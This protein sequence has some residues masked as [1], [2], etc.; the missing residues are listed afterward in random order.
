MILFPYIIKLAK[1]ELLT[2]IRYSSTRTTVKWITIK[3]FVLCNNKQFIG[4]YKCSILHNYTHA[5]NNLSK[6]YA[7]CIST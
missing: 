1:W 3:Y 7:G 5:G 4:V 2:V 6:S